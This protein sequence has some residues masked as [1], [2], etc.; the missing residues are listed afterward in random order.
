MARPTPTILTEQHER[1]RLVQIIAAP[2]NYTLTLDGQPVA[3]RHILP[4]TDAYF[5]YPRASWSN[6]GHADG[7]ARKLNA[8]FKTD[9]F[10]VAKLVAEPSDRQVKAI[11]RAIAGL[12]TAATPP[13][14]PSAPPPRRR[15]TPL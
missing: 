11:A 6:R 1:N 2:E 15:R 10:A 12:A 3:L 4:H 14:A 8:L 9:K 5:K 13:V 7:M